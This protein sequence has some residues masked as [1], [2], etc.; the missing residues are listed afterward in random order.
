MLLLPLLLYARAHTHTHSTAQH[1][2][3]SVCCC[4]RTSRGHQHNTLYARCCGCW[5]QAAQSPQH[6]QRAN[7]AQCTGEA[8]RAGQINAD[9]LDV[10]TIACLGGSNVPHQDTYLGAAMREAR[11]WQKQ[12]RRLW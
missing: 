8:S 10:G 5:Q 2:I 4:Q 3:D 6:D 1:S 12:Q 7:A 9:W 11:R